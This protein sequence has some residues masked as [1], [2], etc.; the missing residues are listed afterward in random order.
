MSFASHASYVHGC[1]SSLRILPGLSPTVSRRPDLRSESYA[2]SP[3]SSAE[4]RS[5]KWMRPLCRRSLPLYRARPV[6]WRP[7]MLSSRCGF[8]PSSISQTFVTVSPILRRR[9]VSVDL[10]VLNHL[11]FQLFMKLSKRRWIVTSSL[12]VEPP[13]LHLLSPLKEEWA[14]AQILL[15]RRIQSRPRP[16]VALRYKAHLLFE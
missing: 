16:A 2:I 11:V 12:L 14:P 6:L 5:L 10:L 3:S 8:K 4:S 9:G 1:S 13:V 7:R 15:P